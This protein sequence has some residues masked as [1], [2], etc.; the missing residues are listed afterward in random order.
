M[1]EV[2]KTAERQPA[3]RAEKKQYV[4]PRVLSVEMLEVVAATCDPN[5]GGKSEGDFACLAGPINS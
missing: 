4:K 1:K 5:A 3:E 2:S